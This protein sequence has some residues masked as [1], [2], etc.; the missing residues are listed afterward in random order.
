MEVKD[1]DIL[2]KPTKEEIEPSI[3]M[4]SD[5]RVKRI[6]ACRAVLW[7]IALGATIY[8]IWWSFEIYNMGIFDPYDYAPMLRPV[9]TRCMLIAVA[10]LVVCLILRAIS[11]RIKKE[12]AYNRMQ[13]QS[14]GEQ[15]KGKE[16]QTENT[17]RKQSV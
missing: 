8:W 10:A 15:D 5:I 7:A 14:S 16:K 6:F 3:I 11:D 1:E 13:A 12:N 4:D 17:I 9:F 2:V